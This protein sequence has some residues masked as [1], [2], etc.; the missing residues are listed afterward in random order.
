MNGQ[1]R[2]YVLQML[3]PRAGF[4][5]WISLHSKC[6]YSLGI[7]VGHTSVFLLVISMGGSL[8]W[9]P[10]SEETFTLEAEKYL[11]SIW[12]GY[13][14]NVSSCDNWRNT[15]MPPENNSLLFSVYFIHYSA[16]T[17]DF[18]LSSVQ[19]PWEIESDSPWPCL[20]FVQRKLMRRQVN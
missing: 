19:S 8:P 6:S 16:F 18:C 20:H 3:M 5:Q 9:D 13:L 10:E 2:I 12:N 4:T 15:F 1:V 7:D 14:E 17:F 11:E